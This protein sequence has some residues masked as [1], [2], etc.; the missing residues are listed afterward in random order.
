MRS[1]R[2]VVLPASAL[3]LTL[4]CSQHLDEQVG[5]Q[6]HATSAPPVIEA[7]VETAALHGYDE[8]PRTPD[9]DDPAIWVNPSASG[10]GLVIGVLK[11][12][13]LQVYDLEGNVV[14]TILPPYRPAVTAQDPPVPGAKPEGGTGP[15]PESGS[16]ETYSRFNNVDVQYGFPLIK[17]DGSEETIDVA[18]VT[19]RGCDRLRIYA[20]KPQSSGGPLLDIT[21]SSAPR[22]FPS[23]LVQPS[24]LQPTGEL[25]GVHDNDLDDQNTAYGLAL[26]RPE[27]D[28][29]GYRAFV[30]QRSRSVVAELE[31][32][33]AGSGKVSYS[34]VRELRFNPAFTVPGAS[35]GSASIQWTPCRE[36]P[37]SDPQFEGLVVD[38]QEGVLFAAQEVVGIWRVPL[39][40]ALPAT[41]NVPAS[42]LFEKTRSFGEPWWAVPDDGEFTCEDTA[43]ATPVAGTI[44]APG[45]PSAGGLHLE[46]D[47]EGLA[48]YY[49]EDEE[50][51]LLVSSQGDDTFHVYDRETPTDHLA[52]FRVEGTGETDGHDVVNVPAGSG[53]PYGLFVVQNG[54]ASG[55]SSEDPISGFEYDG[56]TQFKLL[57]WEDIADELDLDIEED[58]FDP[59]DP[60]D[61]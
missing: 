57:G 52:A 47:V 34:R 39:S 30:T 18:V 61:D 41:V 29:D 28:D 38:Q 23:Q 56:S 12:A 8:A 48:I 19:D 53:F 36:E 26:Y 55:P 27:D 6:D 1:A 24:S 20:I 59:R 58:E 35:A 40:D 11:D 13:G 60:H 3:S 9:A 50:G 5:A 22:V 43:P 25:P 10:E 37:A 7:H 44:A 21:A 15:C 4:G 31:L 46:R 32:H 45:N 42:R 14:Q 16:G 2:F 17:A 54:Q 51:Y 49:G 33:A